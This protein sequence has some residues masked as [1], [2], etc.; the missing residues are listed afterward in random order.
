MRG[1]RWF[2]LGVVGLLLVGW[3]GFELYHA[4]RI[5]PGVTAAGVPVGGLTLEQATSRVG[6]A[7]RGLEPPVLQV[8][9]HTRTVRVTASELG[10]QPDPRATA[11]AALAVGRTGDLARRLGDRF[12]AL[13]HGM[14]VPLKARVDLGVLRARL[15][16]LANSVKQPPLD[17]KLVVEGGLYV[18][19]P[20]RP[21]FKFDLSA[22]VAAYEQDPTRTE[23]ELLTVNLPA[24]V[25]REDLQP[26]AEQANALLRPLTLVYNTGQQVFSRGVPTREVASWVS[27]SGGQVTADRAAI[28]ATVRRVARALDREPADA[29]YVL[30][31]DQLVVKPEQPGWKLDAK[32]A[33]SLLEAVLFDPRR[34][35]VN[36]PVVPAAPRVTAA[37]LPPVEELQL[38]AEASTSFKGSSAERVA[39]VAAAARNLDGYV[40]P[41]GEEFNFNQAVGDI[42]PENG[43]KEALVISGGRTVKGVGGGVCQVSTTA[44]RALY[45]AGLPVVER[46]Q[47]AY[48]VRWYDPIVGYDA[49]VY[50]PYLNLRMKN[51][52]P[53]PLLVR[54]VAKGGVMTVQLY[55]VPDGRKVTVSKPTILSR[56]PHPP[57]QY[58]VDASL[59]PG[60]VKQV[61]WAVD[62]YRTRITRTVVSASGEVKTDVL[63][64]NFRPWRAVYLVGPGTQFGGRG[65]ARASR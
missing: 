39:N 6:E 63:N 54:A 47:H 20:E 10:W 17:A 9:A 55:G 62:G 18:V 30:Q 32:A 21:G 7:T 58:I 27:F 33:V 22:A 65:G 43:F 12:E 36:L 19:E 45:Q 37:D 3:G 44:F 35:G 2:A 40:V 8:R 13:R 4:Q 25:I 51:D 24:K 16:A 61:D 41:A 48:R 42:S 11:E 49:A 29:R 56:T 28:A 52:T 38:L 59:R 23:L 1:F 50:Q 57:A 64:S 53:G 5:Y 31:G 60:Q 34:T 26:L 14:S 15:E 46:N